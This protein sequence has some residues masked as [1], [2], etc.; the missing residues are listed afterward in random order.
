MTGSIVLYATGHDLLVSGRRLGIIV[1][2]RLW[3]PENSLTDGLYQFCT[4]RPVSLFRL[5]FRFDESEC[6]QEC[7]TSEDRSPRCPT[8]VDGKVVYFSCR[9]GFEHNSCHKLHLRDTAKVTE[10]DNDVLVDTVWASSAHDDEFPGLFPPSLPRSAVLAVKSSE[11]KVSRYL[12]FSTQWRSQLRL[13]TV[14]LQD[15]EVTSHTPPGMQSISLLATDGMSRLV[16]VRSDPVSLP[17]LVI[18]EAS[19]QAGRIIIEGHI[20]K[21]FDPS[22][23][24][25]LS[26]QS[27]SASLLARL[28]VS[29][30]L[31]GHLQ[32]SIIRQQEAEHIETIVSSPMEFSQYDMKYPI[33]RCGLSESGDSKKAAP[34]IISL[35]GGPN[36]ASRT[37][38]SST[39]FAL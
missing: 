25:G 8:V 28:R 1:R 27:V 2:S 29:F 12:V 37:G 11:G 34:L 20:V 9:R 22:L 36:G 19:L 39:R 14:D 17:S 32:T 7:L 24:K 16:A 23:P 33:V 35:H 18:G 3:T 13:V 30:P 4:N 10:R 5:E 15:G 21:T 38:W 6:K 31:V 26:G